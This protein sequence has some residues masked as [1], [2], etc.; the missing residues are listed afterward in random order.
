VGALDQLRGAGRR[1]GEVPKLTAGAVNRALAWVR[2]N[3]W[4]T[5]G[6]VAAILLTFAWI[7]WAVY[8]AA[9]RGARE[10]LGVLIAWPA[11]LVGAALVAVPFV[12]SFLL[13]RRQQAERNSSAFTAEPESGAGESSPAK[14]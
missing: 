9:D 14:E 8:V 4:I 12:G 10:G 2:E 5:V 3:P 13:I 7:G 6:V 1:V 11:L